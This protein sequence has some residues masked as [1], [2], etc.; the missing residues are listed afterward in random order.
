MSSAL[1]QYSIFS[2]DLISTNIVNRLETYKEYL[3]FIPRGYSKRIFI[4]GPGI[5]CNQYWYNI[6]EAKRHIDFVLM[7]KKLN[8]K[9]DN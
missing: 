3:L 7:L 2:S 1:V 5:S 9:K 6:N 4:D 8:E